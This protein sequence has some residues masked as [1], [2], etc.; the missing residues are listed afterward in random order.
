MRLT[1]FARAST[2]RARCPEH[3]LRGFAWATLVMV[4]KAKKFCTTSESDKAKIEAKNV[5]VIIDS[6]C[7]IL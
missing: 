3:A 7:A 4:Q 1:L 6:L 2:T 5:Q